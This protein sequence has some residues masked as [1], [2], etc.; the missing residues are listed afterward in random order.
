MPAQ[1]IPPLVIITLGVAGMGALQYGVHWI[2]KPTK[3]ASP[4]LVPHPRAANAAPQP[5][6]QDTCWAPRGAPAGGRQDR[7][8][9]YDARALCAA[10]S[11]PAGCSGSDGTLAQAQPA[12]GREMCSLRLH[13][14]ISAARQG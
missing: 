7:A 6:E 11:A 9:G 13:W 1:S 10:E 12:S 3:V 5:S 2:F 8:S 14:A 4:T